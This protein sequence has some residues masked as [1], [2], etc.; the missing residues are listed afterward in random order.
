MT[1]STPAAPERF[2]LRINTV[3]VL[4]DV[5]DTGTERA[6]APESLIDWYDQALG[7]LDLNVLPDL[8]KDWGFEADLPSEI[9]VLLCSRESAIEIFDQDEA[10]GLFVVNTP[11]TDPF[12]EETPYS[13]HLRVLIVSEK[14]EIEERLREE[15]L[16]DGHAWDRYVGYYQ[17]AEAVTG[18]HEIAHAVL[19]AKNSCGMSANA[20]ELL[21][22][23]GDLNNDIFDMSSGYG[24]RPLPDEDGNVVWAESAADAGSM[25]EAWCEQQGARWYDSIETSVPS[26]YKAAEI[27][28][29][30]L[31]AAAL[32]DPEDEPVV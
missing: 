14:S 29:E 21:S 13:A 12:N 16:A 28:P 31:A 25:M 5:C 17:K 3:S 11:D 19:F 1:K 10:H 2:P 24:V 4:E 32:G 22:D 18:F 9:D 30:A 20:V 15:I 8:E 6:Y 23:A 7:A 26:F 27:D